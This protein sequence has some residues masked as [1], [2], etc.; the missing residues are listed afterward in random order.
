MAQFTRRGHVRS[1]PSGGSTWVSAHDV[2][3]TD[4]DRYGREQREELKI[5]RAL[6]S[7]FVRPNAT[8]PVCGASVF[9]FQNE[10][11]SRVYFDELGPPW[12]K[13]P[14]TS[15][16][17]AA[18]RAECPKSTTQTAPV[19]R[20]AQEIW[21]VQQTFPGLKTT[22]EGKFL[23]EHRKKNWPAYVVLKKIRGANNLYVILRQLEDRSKLKFLL[24]TVDQLSL[25]EGNIAFLEGKK[26]SFFDSEKFEPTQ[27][28]VGVIRSNT[29]FLM[30]LADDPGVA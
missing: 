17:A 14:C 9:F 13:H 18:H 15:G 26:V 12:P 23:A 5:G 29:E 19:L 16:D 24:I 6:T 3:R 20:S 30:R 27:I 22:L 2:S 1:T 10:H 4:W 28:E 25:S 8:C 7:R 11:G 21:R